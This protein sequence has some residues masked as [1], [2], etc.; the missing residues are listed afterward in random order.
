[1]VSF[2]VKTKHPKTQKP[3][4]TKLT[5][6][7]GVIFRRTYVVCFGERPVTS[8]GDLCGRDVNIT[9]Q[10]VPKSKNRLQ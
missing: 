10:H 2:F 9:H 5:S 7:P 1:M 4:N 3:A 8:A 6:V